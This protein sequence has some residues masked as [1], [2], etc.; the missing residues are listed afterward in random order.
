MKKIYFALITALFLATSGFAGNKIMEGKYQGKN[1]Y[2]INSVAESGVGF[3]VFEVRV[4]GDVTTDEV[5]SSAFEI[6]LGIYGFTLGSPV[7]VEI[8]YKDGC[9]PRILNPNALKPQPTFDVTKMDISP[10]GTMIWTTK[11]E[12]GEIPFHVQQFKWNKW[13]DLGEVLG[14]GSNE[15]NSYSFKTNLVSGPNKFRVIQKSSSDKIRKSPI[16]EITGTD[17]PV[18]FSKAKSSVDFS[19]E[20]GYEL[21]NEFGQ[22]VKRGFG[23]A[24]DISEL[25]KGKYYLNYDATFQ[26]FSI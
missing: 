15:T 2:I 3:C 22:I 18:T 1:I 14:K 7:K 9:N 25:P 24:I 5:N 4:N 20:T 23:Q 17:T 19:K 12:E 11:N 13:V 21:F 10:D 6:D 26:E 8:K 16:F